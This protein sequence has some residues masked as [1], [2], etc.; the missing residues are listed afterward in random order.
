[1]TFRIT[2]Q[3]G[4]SAFKQAL[5]FVKENGCSYDSRSKTWTGDAKKLNREIERMAEMRNWTPA[6]YLKWLALE[7]ITVPSDPA[8]TY[9]GQASMD[10]EDSVF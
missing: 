2:A 8:T 1:M 9:V 10:A 6:Q 4:G 5:R 3:L 7:V